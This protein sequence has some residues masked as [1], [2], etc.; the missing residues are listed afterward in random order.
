MSVQIKFRPGWQRD[1]PLDRLYRHLGPRVRGEAQRIVPI[2]TR[3]LHDSINTIVL[4]RDGISILY[5][6]A[7]APHAL[8][9]ELGTYKMAAQSYLRPAAFRRWL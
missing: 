5:L 4:P 2:D 3:E 1:V 7:S 9:V 6:Y 8:F